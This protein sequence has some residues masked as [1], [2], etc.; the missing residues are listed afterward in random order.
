M[1]IITYFQFEFSCS[2]ILS[3]VTEN[4]YITLFVEFDV[5]GGSV[6]FVHLWLA[7][8]YVA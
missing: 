3:V 4:G 8:R 7:C 5:V 6:V 2:D 1:P